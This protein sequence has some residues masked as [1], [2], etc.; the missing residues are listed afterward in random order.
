M[1]EHDAELDQTIRQLQAFLSGL[2]GDRA[3]I[4]SAIT[5]IGALSTAASALL[6]DARPSVAADLDLLTRLA[7]NL[8]ANST[9]IANTLDN[10][11]PRLKA[12]SSTMATGSWINFYACELTGP[13][14]NTRARRPAVHGV[15]R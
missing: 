5:S 10:L 11:G 14:A 7:G 6:T 9:T 15:R 13:I 8:N 12:I 3:A 2:S 1:D 4:S